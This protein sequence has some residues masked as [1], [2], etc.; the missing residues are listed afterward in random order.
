MRLRHH[1]GAAFLAA[2]G[3]GDI[4]IVKRVE[5]GEIAFT[6]DAED[7]ADAIH[8]QLIDQHFA[9][10]AHVVLATHRCPSRFFCCRGRPLRTAARP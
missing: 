3:D 1:H 7:M 4:A 10:A 9:A 5:R 2:D 6:G 8:Q